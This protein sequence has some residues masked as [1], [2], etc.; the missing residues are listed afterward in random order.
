VNAVSHTSVWQSLGF[1][2]RRNL[3]VSFFRISPPGSKKVTARKQRVR[4]ALISIET[5]CSYY[6]SL[7][8]SYLRLSVDLRL[9]WAISGRLTQY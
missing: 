4:D 6:N 8:K 3:S 9:C 7:L 5:A 1:A 2:E